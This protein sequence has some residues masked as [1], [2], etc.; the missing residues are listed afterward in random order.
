MLELSQFHRATSGSE[1]A[2][3]VVLA[4]SSLHT[5]RRVLVLRKSGTHKP[6]TSATLA[7]PEARGSGPRRWP[8]S[9][10]PHQEPPTRT[11]ASSLDLDSLK[12]DQLE[13]L[14]H[15]SEP[16]L[17]AAVAPANSPAEPP[18]GGELLRLKVIPG[19]PLPLSQEPGLPD[20][21]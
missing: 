12:P 13:L 4:T 8:S 20:G 11:K 3:A 6:R 5:L 18:P 2:A 10:R 21:V 7:V 1:L 9:L 14:G 19:L 16:E 15:H 17:S